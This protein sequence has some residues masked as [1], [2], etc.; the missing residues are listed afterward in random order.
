M[1]AAT[2]YVSRTRSLTFFAEL[3][4][5]SRRRLLLLLLLLCCR[6]NSGHSANRAAAA[7]QPATAVGTGF[8]KM[9]DNFQMQT[10]VLT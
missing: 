7:R 3:S 2:D 10:S 8:F 4:C 6:S 1:M 9:N 5:A